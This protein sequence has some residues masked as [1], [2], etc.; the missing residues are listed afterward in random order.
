LWNIWSCFRDNGVTTE[1]GKSSGPGTLVSF[2]SCIVLYVLI[3]PPTFSRRGFRRP[4]ICIFIVAI[5]HQRAWLMVASTEIMQ[6]IPRQSSCDINQCMSSSSPLL[7]GSS[8]I[9]VSI[10][11]MAIH[12]STALFNCFTLLM[13][14][15]KTPALIS[16][17]TLPLIKSRP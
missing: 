15:S 4:G 2:Y 14:G 5:G 12:A 1:D 9:R 17:T 7:S 8:L 3:I 10:R 6:H 16:S 13:F 11:M